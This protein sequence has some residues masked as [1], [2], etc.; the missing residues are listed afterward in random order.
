MQSNDILFDCKTYEEKFSLTEETAIW[1]ASLISNVSYQVNLAI[2]KG[3]VF[4]GTVAVN[5]DLSEIPTK[6]IGLDFVG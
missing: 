6:S 1:R 2:L 3:D 4:L 5:F